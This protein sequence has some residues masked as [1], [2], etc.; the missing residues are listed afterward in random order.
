MA[1]HTAC[2]AWRRMV[3]MAPNDVHGGAWY[4]CQRM[5]AHGT[6][7]CGNGGAWVCTATRMMVM[8]AHNVPC[9]NV[10]ACTCTQV[11][12]YMHTVYVC[13]WWSWRHVGVHSDAH[14]C[15]GCAWCALCA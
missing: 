14:G 7:T 4:E 5:A 8:A 2:C 11:H 9:V 13:T 1:A 6:C 15:H 10:G 12:A 3:C